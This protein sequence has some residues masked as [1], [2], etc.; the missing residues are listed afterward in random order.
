[1]RSRKNQQRIWAQETRI[2]WY[3]QTGQIKGKI[4]SKRINYNVNKLTI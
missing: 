4:S 3:R 1:M 2:E